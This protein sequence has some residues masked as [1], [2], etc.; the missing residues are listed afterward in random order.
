[1][2]LILVGSLLAGGACGCA[3]HRGT[4]PEARRKVEITLPELTPVLTGPAGTLLTSSGDFESDWTLTLD[5]A[6]EP[7]LNLTGKLFVRGGKLHLETAPGKSKAIGVNELGLIWDAATARGWVYSE[8]LQGYASIDGATQFTNLHTAMLADAPFTLAGHP[9]DHAT[10]TCTGSGGSTLVLQL[11]RARDLGNLPLQ[12]QSTIGNIVFNLTLNQVKPTQPADAFFLPP[13]GFTAYKS[14]TALVEELSIR[15]ESVFGE[16]T[17]RPV[18]ETGAG[19]TGG[20][21][22]DRGPGGAH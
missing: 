7:T 17:F 10:A 20:P 8:A 12:I 5:N 2:N 4:S 18:G 21:D 22:R 19:E 3:H 6:P 13:D 14:E 15:Q 9:V 1:M 11:V 16:Q